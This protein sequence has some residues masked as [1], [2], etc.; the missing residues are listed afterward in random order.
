MLVRVLIIEDEE[1]I[2]WSLRA[3]FESLGYKVTEAG[4]GAEATRAL[5]SGVF[6]LVMPDYRLPD[7]TGIDLLRSI[8]EADQDV[9]VIMMTAYSSVETAVDAGR[10]LLYRYDPRRFE[11][12]LNPLQLDSPAPKLPLKRN[13]ESENR[14]RMLMK[15]QPQAAARLAAEAQEESSRRYREYEWMAAPLSRSGE[16]KTGAKDE[17][18]KTSAT[19]T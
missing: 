12:D 15:S 14:F 1:L 7:T 16:A 11:K 18:A 10:W 13:L 2:R 5:D 8:R 19:A 6:D 17:A 9:V 4:D 3:K